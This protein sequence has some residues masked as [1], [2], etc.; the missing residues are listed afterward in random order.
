MLTCVSASECAADHVAPEALQAAIKRQNGA[1]LEMTLKVSKYKLSRLYKHTGCQRNLEFRN[2]TEHALL[3][4]PQNNAAG[5]VKL[6]QHQ[7]KQACCDVC[8]R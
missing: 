5:S 6:Q 1:M 2:L 8:L 3:H 4:I 7:I